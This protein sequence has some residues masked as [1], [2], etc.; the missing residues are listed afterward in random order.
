MYEVGLLRLCSLGKPRSNAW[1]AEGLKVFRRCGP[2]AVAAAWE[3][4]TLILG[5]L[6]W[7]AWEAM[8]SEKSKS[9]YS[10]TRNRR[11][12]SQMTSFSLQLS[13]QEAAATACCSCNSSSLCSA[14]V[15]VYLT[16]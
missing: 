1:E 2:L 15:E 6:S 5:R 4:L 11:L 8:Y 14:L 10:M 16:T 12:L 3:R 7:L 9:M 13:T